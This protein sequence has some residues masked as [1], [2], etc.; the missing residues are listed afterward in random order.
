MIKTVVQ[1]LQSQLLADTSLAAIVGTR[2]TL[3]DDVIKM[4]E[5]KKVPFVNIELDTF[6]VENAD[7]MRPYDYER[8][9]YKIKLQFCVVTKSRTESLLGKT[10]V[11]GLLD[12]YDTLYDAIKADATL[13]G[14]VDDIVNTPTLIADIFSPS[15]EELF[16]VAGGEMEVSFYKDVCLR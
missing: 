16:Y 14:A 10:G 4:I 1:N 7:N 5:E 15:K 12:M 8:H 9:V 3:A 13:S 6:S 2:V 11:T